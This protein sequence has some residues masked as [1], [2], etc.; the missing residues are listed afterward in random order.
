MELAEEGLEQAG[1]PPQRVNR[2][3]MEELRS[4]Q[5][6]QHVGPPEL[7]QQT[8]SR[9]STC[10]VDELDPWEMLGKSQG[11]WLS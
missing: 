11:V 3:A 6:S 4:Q 5:S 10:R 2:L 7:L 1:Q 9:R 8:E